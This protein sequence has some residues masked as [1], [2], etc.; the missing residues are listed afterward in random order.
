MTPEEE[1]KYSGNPLRKL[2][3]LL[4]HVKRKCF[5]LYQQPSSF[6]GYEVYCDNFYTSPSLLEGL[7][8]LGILATGTFRI[9]RHGIPDDVLALKSALEKKAV[10]RGT[11]YYIREVSAR[12]VYCLWKDT[13]VVS[14][15]STAHPGH[16][17][18]KK[19][20]RYVSDPDAGGRKTVEVPR[21][22]SIE[23]CNQNMGGVDKPN[24]FSL[25]ITS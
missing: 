3:P 11:G 23:R 7:L 16:Q 12:I 5:E 18:D 6:Q 15:M 17:S 22:T 8:T 10:T 4:D 20:S 1:V 9:T 14:V 24:S 21:P 13:R 2:Q 19:V 25:T